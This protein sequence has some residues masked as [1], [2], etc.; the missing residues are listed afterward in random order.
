MYN[1]CIHIYYFYKFKKYAAL[2][3]LFWPISF[4]ISLSLLLLLTKFP[5]AKYKCCLNMH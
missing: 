4:K 3:F 5:T 1:I 2:L